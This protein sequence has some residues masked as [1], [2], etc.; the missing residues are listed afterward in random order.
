MK[1][2]LGIVVALAA[3]AY[4]REIPAYEDEY[5]ESMTAYGYLTRFGIPEAERIRKLEEEMLKSPDRIAGGTASALGEIPYQ[6]GLLSEITGLSGNGICG[7]SLLNNL[8]VLT[9]AHCWWDGQNQAWRF[10][11]VLGS[12]TLFSG[13][14]R[15]QSTS[16]VVHPNWNPRTI[17]NDVAII[18]LPAPVTLSATI[19]PIALPTTNENFAGETAVASGFGMRGEESITTA[20]FKSH[21]SL[22]II[23]NLVCRLSF[24]FNVQ[25]SNICTSGAGGMSTCRGDSGGP[26]AVTRNN[27]RIL[28]GV[29]SFGSAA[30]CTRGFPLPCTSTLSVS[31]GGS[32]LYS[33]LDSPPP[34]YPF[35]QRTPTPLRLSS[36]YQISYYYPRD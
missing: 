27:Q 13:G 23:T 31:F 29:T 9:A 35:Y 3:V 33:L 34:H 16:V 1:C 22:S 20:Q 24:P 8:R 25:N 32:L 14:T 30:G 21:V 7:G 18:N 17:A 12:I 11:V 5:L 2:F 28:V 15:V 4:A 26:L 6:A 36:L 10:T 19:S